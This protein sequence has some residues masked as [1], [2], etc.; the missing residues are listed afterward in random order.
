MEKQ[1]G[2]KTESTEEGEQVNIDREEGYVSLE[3]RMRQQG[4]TPCTRVLLLEHSLTSPTIW[5]CTEHCLSFG[6]LDGKT[7]YAMRNVCIYIYI[8]IYISVLIYLY[9][10]I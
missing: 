8:Y 9:I 7:T 2:R 10:Y 1:G 6:T 3:V 5:R 4:W